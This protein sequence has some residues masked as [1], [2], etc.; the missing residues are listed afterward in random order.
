MSVFGSH[1]TRRQ[2]L[3]GAV[4]AS[5]VLS[6]GGAA[7]QFLRQLAAREPASSNQRVLVVVQL[8][9]GND[10]LNTVVPHR[11]DRYRK[12]RPTLAVPSNDVLKINS[13]LGWHPGA[14]GL[15]DLLEAQRLAVIQG[16]GYPN[17]NRSHFESM[18]I[19]HSCDRKE[20]RR[21]DGWL[22][23]VLDRT[24]ATGD[25]P[26][27]HL[28]DKKQPLAL[29]AQRTRTPSIKSLDKFRLQAENDR[30]LRTDVERLAKAKREGGND[31]LGFV[32]TSASSALAAS[33]RVESARKRYQ[34]KANYPASRLSQKLRTVA[35]LIDAGLKTRIYY[36]VLDG[37]DTH[38]LQADAH[39]ALLR[40]LGGALQ[41]FVSD[42]DQHGHGDRTTVMCFSEFGRR[43]AENASKG[44]DH[45]AAGPMFLAGNK[46]RAG[47]IGKHPDL[48]KLKQG[49]VQHHTDFRRVYAAVLEKW[50]GYE[51]REILGGTYKP[52]P[53]FA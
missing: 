44:T 5:T 17:P 21:T 4:G 7:P 40:Q 29:A 3:Q 51:T 1:G 31:L 13:D 2:F 27:L 33:Q 10:G 45:G 50:L 25:V 42:I 19:W 28:G 48:G 20:N 32:Q 8:S 16:V 53:V 18:D 22:G 46:V 41:A 43:V 35:Q 12:A 39:S 37:F 47:L 9:G 49:D 52:L 15:A 26:A 36:V 6:L 34:P 24:P 11:D 30:R 23:R 14:R 38:S